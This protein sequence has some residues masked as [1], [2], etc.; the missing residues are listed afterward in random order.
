MVRQSPTPT[1]EKTLTL[2]TLVTF[3]SQIFEEE[4]FYFPKGMFGN[5][6]GIYKI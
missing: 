3:D 4:M 6:I 5:M 1:R 2:L